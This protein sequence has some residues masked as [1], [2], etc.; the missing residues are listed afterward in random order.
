MIPAYDDR[1]T[2]F[3]TGYHLVKGPADPIPISQSEPADTAGHA[4]ERNP[5]ARHIQPLVQ[6]WIIGNQFLDFFIGA[7]DILRIAR[8]RCPAK[9]P[10]TPTEQRAHICGDKAGVVEGVINAGFLSHLAN[11]VAVVDNRNASI[12]KIEHCPNLDRH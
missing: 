12:P 11:I 8:Q 10:Y 1:C 7:E 9:R 3:A 6:L 5:V 2:Q 4:L